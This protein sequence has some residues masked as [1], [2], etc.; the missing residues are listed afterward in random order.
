MLYIILNIYTI[1]VFLS[2]RSRTQA[3]GASVLLSV[4]I[5]QISDDDGR[6]RTSRTFVSYMLNK[7]TL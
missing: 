1:P 7:H 6:L 5:Q 2:D 4:H 3:T